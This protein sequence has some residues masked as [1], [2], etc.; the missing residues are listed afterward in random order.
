MLRT[1][2][3][4]PGAMEESSLGEGQKVLT[5]EEVRGPVLISADLHGNWEDFARLRDLFLASHGRGEDPL[6]IGVGDWVHG[7]A[8]DTSY[9]VD[10]EGRPLYDYPDESPRILD[11]LFALMDAHPGRVVSI[12]GN[13]EHAHIGG[14]RTSRFAADETLVLEQRLG[15]EAS[16]W[17]AAWLQSFPL[18]AIAPCG[19]LLSHGAPGGVPPELAQLEAIDYGRYQVL[20]EARRPGPPEEGRNEGAERLLGQLLWTRSLSPQAA[21]KVLAMTGARVLVYGREVVRGAEAI[22]KEQLVLSS[23]FGLQDGDKRVLEVDLSAR[24]QSAAELREGHE[25][26]PL[27]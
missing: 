10:D 7:P 18:W 15:E 26:L 5:L 27:Y 24:Y 19:L 22:G 9:L 13:H 8:G 11:A 25:I 20:G 3:L 23:S 6:W 14:P 12:L 21:R 1:E 4:Y 2:L 17:L 16:D